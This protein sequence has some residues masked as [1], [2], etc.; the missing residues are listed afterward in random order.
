MVRLSAIDTR[1]WCSKH[2]L[3]QSI[4]GHV[5]EADGKD[6]GKAHKRTI[7]ECEETY[8]R[9]VAV[10]GESH[11]E[12]LALELE[13]SGL[14]QASIPRS[15]LGSVTAD[16]QKV[17]QR[18]WALVDKAWVAIKERLRDCNLRIA[19]LYLRGRIRLFQGQLDDAQTEYQAALECARRVHGQVLR[20][21]IS[22]RTA[23][24]MYRHCI[25]QTG[26]SAMGFS[27]GHPIYLV[28]LNELL[29]ASEMQGI[30]LK[31]AKWHNP[32]VLDLMRSCL[33]EHTAVHHRPAGHGPAYDVPSR[34]PEAAD[35]HLRPGAAL[36]CK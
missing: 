34:R 23:C 26:Q 18:A 2:D 5:D 21:S 30:K 3:V 35:A 22:V 12:L 20:M 10:L 27:H 29:T 31:D 36:H 33:T 32:V 11:S 14:L 28:L 6:E 15:Q 13:L 17:L 25:L 8:K 4:R 9:A 24:V 1:I 16:Q 7:A 19:I